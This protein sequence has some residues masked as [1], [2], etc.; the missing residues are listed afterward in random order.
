M[1]QSNG[2]EAV[3]HWQCK[4]RVLFHL[5]LRRAQSSFSHTQQ[6]VISAFEFSRNTQSWQCWH[7]CIAQIWKIWQRNSPHWLKFKARW[8]R[9]FAFKL[10][11]FLN[12]ANL[13]TLEVV[14][15]CHH[16]QLCAL[17]ENSYVVVK[18]VIWSFVENIT[19]PHFQKRKK[20]WSIWIKLEKLNGLC[21]ILYLLLWFNLDIFHRILLELHA[22]ESTVFD[23]WIKKI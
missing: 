14:Q 2:I 22:L 19:T 16:C 4:S 21:Q 5:V 12:V 10:I 18:L 8:Q 15:K 9:K 11:R 1:G 23:P 17:R 3:H 7:F 6:I 13:F 20:K